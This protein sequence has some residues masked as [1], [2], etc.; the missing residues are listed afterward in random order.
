MGTVAVHPERQRRHRPPVAAQQRVRDRGG[1]ELGGVAGSAGA[2][3]G[4]NRTT[5][6]PSEKPSP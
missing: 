5:I 2:G 6:R 1:K 4:A 3:G